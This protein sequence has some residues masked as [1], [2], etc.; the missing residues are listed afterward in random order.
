M[1]SKRAA[2]ASGPR[3]SGPSRTGRQR[4]WPHTSHGGADLPGHEFVV[5]VAQKLALGLFPR[6]D[7]QYGVEN[8]LPLGLDRDAV[9]N[10]AAIDIHVVEHAAVNV[11]VGGELD[12]RRRLAAIGRAATRRKTE[13]VAAT[14]HL[15]RRR[16]GVV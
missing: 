9:E 1:P 8:L 7:A 16:D 12:R 10:V 5:A 14:R 3:R 11:V 4:G 13:Q 15:A 6:G 2:G